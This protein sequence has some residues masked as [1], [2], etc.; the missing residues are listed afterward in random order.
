MHQGQ[1]LDLSYGSNPNESDKAYGYSSASYFL[2]LGGNRTNTLMLEAKESLLKNRSLVGDEEFANITVNVS[3]TH[4]LFA[5]KRTVLISADVTNLKTLVAKENSAA[6]SFKI[7]DPLYDIRS[8]EIGTYAGRTLR[9]DILLKKNQKNGRL[10]FVS[11]PVKNAFVHSGKSHG[12]AAGDTLRFTAN[13]GGVVSGKVVG[14][15]VNCFV[16]NG[17]LNGELHIVGFGDIKR[18]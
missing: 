4:Y 7:G 14:F 8:R 10:K 13:N 3:T 1:L 5:Q 17:G 11:Y 9:G 16:I 15:G 2:N 12:I 6:R 18:E